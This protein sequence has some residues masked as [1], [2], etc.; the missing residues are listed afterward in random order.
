MDNNAE[1]KNNRKSSIV[2]EWNRNKRIHKKMKF[3]EKNEKL[4]WSSFL[5]T[6]KKTFKI[7]NKEIDQG[8]KFGLKIK[9]VHS[10]YEIEIFNSDKKIVQ[11]KWNNEKDKYWM[12]FKLR[13]KI[14]FSGYVIKVTEFIY[15]QT[16]FW[17]FQDT[18][19]MLWLK[20]NFKN[21]IKKMKQGINLVLQNNGE[22]PE[23]IEQYYE[24]KLIRKKIKLKSN[25]FDELLNLLKK[26]FITKINFEVNK[27]F[28]SK[29]NKY[30]IIYTV[31]KID[32]KNKE[33]IINWK[34]GIDKYETKFFLDK[35]ILMIEQKIDSFWDIK[36]KEKFKLIKSDFKEFINELKEIT[37]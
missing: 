28:T 30:S 1:I 18:L 7:H 2:D 31:S 33:I 34:Q 22:I 14:L 8:L 13:K 24:S 19:G 6:F 15:R 12:K 27:T 4:L 11:I 26:Q 9:N 32:A 23:N 36:W 3:K 21:E 10:D 5:V 25:N 37:K 29:K 35:N 16:P 17:G 20:S